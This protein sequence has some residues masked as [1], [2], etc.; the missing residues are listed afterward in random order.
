MTR[1]FWQHRGRP[2]ALTCDVAIVG[3]GIAGASAAFWLRRERPDWTVAL[4]DAVEPGYGASG[5]NAGFLLQGIATDYVTDIARY[6]RA[7]AQR[8]WQFTLENRQLL[9]KELDPTA[10]DLQRTG[11]LIVAGTAA[12]DERLQRSVTP[13]RADGVPVAYVPPQEVSSRAQAGGFFGALNVPS[14]A[15]CD[16]LKLVRHIIAQSGATVC[17]QHRVIDV[18]PQNGM[19]HLITPHRTVVAGQ[20]LVTTNAAPVPGLVRPEGAIRPKRAQMLATAPLTSRVLSC[21]M[22]SHEGNYY[23]RQL[24]GGE[25]LLGGARHQHA[26][27][28]VGFADAT[29]PPVQDAL[30]AYLQ[31]HFPWAA[32]AQVQRRWSGTMG[33]TAD[34]LPIIGPV[35]HAP[36]SYWAGGFNGHGMGLAFRFGRLLAAMVARDEAPDAASLFRS[37]RPAS[38]AA[39]SAV[40]ESAPRS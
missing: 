1:S 12:E 33:F 25:V 32:G 9:E 35:P 26:A 36:G 31:R 24:P 29:T 5:R 23:L 17:P 10:F 28:E 37:D 7:V 13:L 11:S 40:T 2:P 38:V 3:A 21:P 22:Y 18:M 20:M 27:A 16:P 15:T 34:R 6:G 8:L 39:N 30:E 4:L 19:V 14:G